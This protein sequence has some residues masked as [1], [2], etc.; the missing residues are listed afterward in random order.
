MSGGACQSVT[1]PSATYIRMMAMYLRRAHEAHK[2]KHEEAG[3]GT[4]LH[5]NSCTF[6]DGPP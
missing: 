5:S 6:A 1:A 2:G 4:A 3:H